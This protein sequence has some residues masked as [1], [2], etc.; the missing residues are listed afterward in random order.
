MSRDRSNTVVVS[1]L[2]SRRHSA[3]TQVWN[4]RLHKFH[5]KI[6]G[7]ECE[8][9]QMDLKE[10]NKMNTILPENS[11]DTIRR[12]LIS[13]YVLYFKHWED[14]NLLVAFIAMTGLVC[15]LIDYEY[16]FNQRPS[17][18]S[19]VSKS[20]YTTLNQDIISLI[21]IVAV[22]LQWRLEAVWQQ[23]RNPIKFYR[24]MLKKQIQIGLLDKSELKKKSAIHDSYSKFTLTSWR[25][26]FEIV[27]MLVHVNP[28][29]ERL[30]F[31]DTTNWLDPSGQYPLGSYNY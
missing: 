10:K 18:G 2:P 15:A 30:V 31:I 8:F 14:F 25:F 6:R 26:W 5:D 1:E 19:L 29:A 22:I 28:W 17:D 27:V 21:G 13:K 7:M 20:Y 23:Y 24:T 12:D 3:V 11:D 16:E 9:S 4:W